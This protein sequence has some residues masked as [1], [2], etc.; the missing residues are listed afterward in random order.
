MHRFRER[1][2]SVVLASVIVVLAVLVLV[3]LVV[4]AAGGGAGSG[5]GRAW[6]GMWL[7]FAMAAVAIAVGVVVIV[8]GKPGETHYWGMVG[9][10]TLAALVTGACWY[11]PAAPYAG[12]R[13]EAIPMRIG[14]WRGVRHTIDERTKRVLATEDMIMR[15]YRRGTDVVGLAVIFAMGSRKVAHPPE[16]CY[17]AGGSELED[18]AEDSFATKDGRTVGVRRLVVVTQKVTT[19][20]LYWYRAGDL[21]TPSFVRQ[22]WHVILSSLNPFVRSQRRV[23]LIRLTT[24]LTGQGDMLRAR[25]LLKEF[26]REVFPEIEA[27]LK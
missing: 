19:A 1:W 18:S 22:Q 20:V 24:G 11:R 15:S 9:A 23:A 26:A 2:A 7:G 10:L 12:Q 8:R 25:A 13:A 21:N 14:E 5:D 16:Q 4:S 17:A 3:D 6:L 27:K